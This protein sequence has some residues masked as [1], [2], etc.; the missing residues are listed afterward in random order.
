MQEIQVSAELLQYRTDDSST[1]DLLESILRAVSKSAVIISETK[2]IEQLA[3]LPLSERS[4][5]DTLSESVKAATLL[6]E[7]VEFHLSLQ[8]SGAQIRADEYLELLLSDL[9]ANA[10]EHNPSD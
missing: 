6:L 5:D 2:T 8:V 9:L 4:L 7:D 10:Y 3:E 1:R